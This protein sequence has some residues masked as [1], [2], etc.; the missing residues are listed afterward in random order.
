MTSTWEASSSGSGASR[1]PSKTVTPFRR[2]QRAATASSSVATTRA[3][4]R[5]DCMTTAMA[6][7]PVHRS[8]PHPLAGS[9]C[10]AS[11]AS[12]SD[13]HLGT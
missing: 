11:R 4:G 1:S 5:V 7:D 10:A 8:T 9:S 13:C 12:G 3:S 2:A 6:P